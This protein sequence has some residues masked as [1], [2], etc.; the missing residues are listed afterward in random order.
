MAGIM[1][2]RSSIGKHFSYPL[3][4]VIDSRRP[5]PSVPRPKPERLEGVKQV[6]LVAGFKCRDGFVVGA[7]TEVTHGPILFQGHKLAN[8]YPDHTPVYDLIVGGAGNT[9][10]LTMASQK[11]RDAIAAL[12]EPTLANIKDEVQK[13]ISGIYDEQICKLWGIG[14]P[15]CPT[16]SLIIGVE[17]QDKNIGLL[18]TENNAVFEVEESAFIGFGSYLA[19]HLS[20]KLWSST[21]S[22]AATCHI[23]QQIFREAKGKGTYVG[24]NTE[25]IARL[26]KSDAEP[27][28]N[29]TEKDYRYIWGLEE[30]M[31]SAVRIALSKDLDPN[32][33]NERIDLLT[34]RLKQLRETAERPRQIGGTTIRLTEFGSETGNWM[35]NTL[36]ERWK[37]PKED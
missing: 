8:Y 2:N 33:L 28:F 20:E 15:D 21:L 3:K 19:E 17:D 1:H 13:V 7:D 32:A 16:V 31:L 4:H 29:L 37:R 34:K 23:A 30:F 18:V 36:T 10:Y 14:D 9:A 11:I 22:T 6:T 35:K 26:V 24:G 27:F 12:T 5:R 25:I